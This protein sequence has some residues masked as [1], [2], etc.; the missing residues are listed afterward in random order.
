MLRSVDE[1]VVG[2]ATLRLK[3][4]YPGSEAHKIANVDIQH[5]LETVKRHEIDVG[6]WINVI[7]YIERQTEK[8]G[9]CVQAVAIW[10]AG[11]V[12]LDAYY[13]SVVK[14]KNAA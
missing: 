11:N 3:H 9:I 12:D 6:A 7:G 4:Q 5:L 13:N 1:Y 14:R 8:K 2:K 10:D